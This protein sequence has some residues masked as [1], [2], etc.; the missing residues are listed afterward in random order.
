MN[1]LKVWKGVW[2]IEDGRNRKVYVMNLTITVN[3]NKSRKQ[4]VSIKYNQPVQLFML[5]GRQRY[6]KILS[7]L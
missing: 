5:I 6:E 2:Y 4:I 3:F 7:L 1:I